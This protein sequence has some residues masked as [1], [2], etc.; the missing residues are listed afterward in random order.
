MNMHIFHGHNLNPE[1]QTELNKNYVPSST[2]MFPVFIPKRTCLYIPSVEVNLFPSNSGVIRQSELLAHCIPGSAACWVTRHLRHI[3]T[4]LHKMQRTNPHEQNLTK[5]PFFIMGDVPVSEPYRIF[6][7]PK[8]MPLR[9]VEL[10]RELILVTMAT[11]MSLYD[12][13]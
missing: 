4:G 12:R 8:K 3:V 5:N 2:M 7:G 10:K 1:K 6:S 13:H 11:T 9:G